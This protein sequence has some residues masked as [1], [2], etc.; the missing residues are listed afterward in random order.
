[1]CV[2]ISVVHIHVNII[3]KDRGTV[4]AR[5]REYPGLRHL[6]TEEGT[7]TDS[8]EDDRVRVFV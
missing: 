5:L 1:M 2:C 3:P 7:G 8:M 4:E 6:I